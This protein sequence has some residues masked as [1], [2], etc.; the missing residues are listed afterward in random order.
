MRGKAFSVLAI[1]AAAAS[2]TSWPALAQSD[3]D[4]TL[5][6]ASYNCVPVER[7]DF[8]TVLPGYIG[9]VG[10]DDGYVYLLIGNAQTHTAQVS[11]E[12]LQ[13]YTAGCSRD[14]MTTVTSTPGD[15]MRGSDGTTLGVSFTF[16]KYSQNCT[17]YLT[18]INGN[19]LECQWNG[20]TN[21]A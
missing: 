8:S 17:M 13:A 19:G 20:V 3:P 4:S 9:F 16:A 21:G 5:D 1:A 12:T 15:A 7:P 14:C 2:L 18:Q 6:T 10:C 11:F